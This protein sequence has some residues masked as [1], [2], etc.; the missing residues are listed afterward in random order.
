PFTLEFQGFTLISGTYQPIKANEKGWLYSEQLDLY[1]GLHKG[2]LR[3]FTPD[4]ELVPT[5]EESAMQERQKANKLA[6]KLRELGINPD[7]IM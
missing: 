1:L 2:K 7:E 4:G 5:P 3:Y 6:E